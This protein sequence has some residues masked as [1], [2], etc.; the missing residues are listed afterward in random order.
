MAGCE[1]RTESCVL[2]LEIS[3]EYNNPGALTDRV[4]HSVVEQGVFIGRLKTWKA[5][6][7]IRNV[8]NIKDAMRKD[9]E[10]D[11]FHP[12][13]LSRETVIPEKVFYIN[14][15]HSGTVEPKVSGKLKRLQTSA[16]R[17]VLGAQGQAEDISLDNETEIE[18][19]L[20]LL[21][22]TLEDKSQ[23]IM[24]GIP[25]RYCDAVSQFISTLPIDNDLLKL[26]CFLQHKQLWI[27][28]RL[29]KEARIPVFTIVQKP[30][31]IVFLL[32]NTIHWGVNHGFNYNEAMNYVC[33]SWVLPGMMAKQRC[34][35]VAGWRSTFDIRSTLVSLGADKEML[36]EW[37][38]G[39]T[40]RIS[41]ALK[42]S[43]LSLLHPEMCSAGSE[44]R[45]VPGTQEDTPVYKTT[46]K[47]KGGYQC[48]AGPCTHTKMYRGEGAKTALLNH[49][50][51]THQNDVIQLSQIVENGFLKRAASS[52][53]LFT[54]DYCC[55]TLSGAKLRRTD[56]Q[57]KCG[58]KQVHK[59][60]N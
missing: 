37:Q 52:G 18:N 55:Q 32:P 9:S 43:S 16:K 49:I 8:N 12:D 3:E 38:T 57:D 45:P 6:D 33:S 7:G 39:L 24:F 23:D 14:P 40:T 28:P 48:P 51:S 53:T 30:G 31:D 15:L 10:M 59:M 17:H 13:W 36:S 56:H 34:S 46:I 41:N 20:D 21:L 60:M 19:Y 29:L 2:V 1:V 22:S 26:K 27:D 50:T 11:L 25:P 35:C 47:I 44:D 54:C 42:T 58:R 4:L 5:E